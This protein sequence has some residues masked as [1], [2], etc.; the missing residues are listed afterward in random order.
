MDSRAWRK[1]IAI[2]S[3]KKGSKADGLDR[4]DGSE[5]VQLRQ[6]MSCLRARLGSWSRQVESHEATMALTAHGDADDT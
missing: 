4:L 2:A 3:S 1:R 5:E 6:L